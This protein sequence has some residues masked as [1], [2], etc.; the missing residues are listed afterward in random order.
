MEPVR[1]GYMETLVCLRSLVVKKSRGMGLVAREG[2]VFFKKEEIV[3][4]FRST[5]KKIRGTVTPFSR[6]TR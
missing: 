4:Y 5:Q 3:G 2:W 6:Q 1:A